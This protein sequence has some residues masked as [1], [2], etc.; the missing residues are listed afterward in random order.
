MFKE[1]EEED[2]HQSAT[3]NLV[4]KWSY[5]DDD[6]NDSV[7]IVWEKFRAYPKLENFVVLKKEKK[8]TG[9]KINNHRVCTGQWALF[10]F[11]SFSKWR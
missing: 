11:L 1:E 9:F 3:N 2:E 8:K 7:R 10:T 5:D 6:D 4:L